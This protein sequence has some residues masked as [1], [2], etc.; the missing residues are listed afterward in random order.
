[1]PL[2]IVNGDAV[3]VEHPL[4]AICSTMEPCP[5][6]GDAVMM[7]IPLIGKTDA[8]ASPSIASHPGTDSPKA[9]RHRPES[10]LLDVQMVWC[11]HMRAHPETGLA[12]PGELK[13]F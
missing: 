11:L 12:T 13:K 3:L 9:N 1:M 5:C 7:S 10:R 8:S 6:V 2:A 4:T